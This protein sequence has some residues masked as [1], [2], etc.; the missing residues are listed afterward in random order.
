MWINVRINIKKHAKG[1][2]WYD[3][4]VEGKKVTYGFSIFKTIHPDVYAAINHII[5]NEELK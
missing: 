4:Y 5:K 3:I 2:K 1:E